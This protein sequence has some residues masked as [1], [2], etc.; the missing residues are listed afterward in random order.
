MLTSAYLTLCQVMNTNYRGSILPQVS[1]DES[2]SPPTRLA[3]HHK[4]KEIQKT[5]YVRNLP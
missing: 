4:P 2:E 3:S 5:R 1:K